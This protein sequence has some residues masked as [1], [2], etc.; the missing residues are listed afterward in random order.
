M[1]A[2]AIDAPARVADREPVEAAAGGAEAV[3]VM[4]PVELTMI[5]RVHTLIMDI[6][7]RNHGQ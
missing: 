4:M 5:V 3:M 2:I 7:F 1:A 6:P